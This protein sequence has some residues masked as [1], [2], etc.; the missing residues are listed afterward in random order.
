[1][2]MENTLFYGDCL[3]VLRKE[4]PSESVDLIYLDPPFNS[5]RDY[6]AFFTSQDGRHSDAQ[7]MAFED[8]WHWGPQ[9]QMEYEAL[10]RNPDAGILAQ[11][12]MPALRQFLAQSDMMTYL[13]M[14]ASRLVE[15]KRVLKDTGSLY[16]HCD[17][18]ASHYLK[19]L[20][21]GVFGAVNFK[22]EII[23][24][25][26]GSHNSAK[27][28]GPIHDV[29]LFYTKG[30]NYIWNKTYRPYAKGYV[31]S[32]F[33]GE[34]S[35]GRFRKTCLT[36]AGKRNGKSGQK[37][38]N[39]DPTSVSRHWAIPGSFEDE[40]DFDGKTPQEKLDILDEAGLIFCSGSMP[41]Y[42]QYLNK[43][44]GV[45]YQDIWAY[46]PYTNGFYEGVSECIDEDIRWVGDRNDPERLGYPTQKP[47]G[48]LERIILS[49]SNVGDVVLDPF[50]GCGTAIHA[51]QKSGRKWIGID[52][53]H[54]AVGLIKRRMHEAFPKE[55][56]KV[57]GTPQDLDAAHFLATTDKL[58]GR[59]QFQYWALSLVDAT[60]ANDGKRGADGGSDGFIWANSSPDLSKPFKI[61]ISVKS[62]GIPAN[63][64]RE[65]GGMLGKDNIEICVLI[66]LSP[67]SSKMLADALSYGSYRYPNGKEFPKI[68]ILTIADLL[69][70]KQINFLDYGDGQGRIK[71]AKREV[72][73]V[74]RGSLL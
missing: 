48:L 56:F 49:S 19:I 69:A 64:I 72:K 16:L 59:Y 65:L 5:Q 38:R 14:M 60:P 12:I 25:R 43:S 26:S 46:Q 42:R 40:F 34:D 4:I 7:I 9:S 20:L 11:S 28:Y 2:N 51:A 6:N 44:K 29:I 36:G 68:Q 62:G 39:F 61:N 53:T 41:E 47:I 10:L 52:I 23:W 31:N 30:R 66:T 15:L 3:D 70:G 33:T 35:Q 71:K 37:W 27:R 13:V 73:I 45:P 1:M 18:T 32:F 22:N 50:C 54:L 55:H 21:D 67:P 57:R 8:T 74:Q 63:H 17:P 58:E 24:R